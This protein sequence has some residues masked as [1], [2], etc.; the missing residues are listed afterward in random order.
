MA[1][2]SWSWFQDSRAGCDTARLVSS[3]PTYEE[4]DPASSLAAPRMS[5]RSDVVSEDHVSERASPSAEAAPVFDNRS[6]RSL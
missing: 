1:A 4:A 5:W 6:D 3:P 2:T